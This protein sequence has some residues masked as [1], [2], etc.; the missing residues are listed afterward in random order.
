MPKRRRNTRGVLCSC[1]NF[2][3]EIWVKKILKKNESSDLKRNNTR[4]VRNRLLSVW[5][6]GPSWR[7]WR[8]WRYFPLVSFGF[9]WQR[10]SRTSVLC[11]AS[12]GLNLY[13]IPVKWNDADPSSVQTDDPDPGPNSALYSTCSLCSVC[14]DL[15]WQLLYIIRT[16]GSRVTELRGFSKNNT[17]SANCF[18][19]SFFSLFPA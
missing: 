6:S 1:L 12:P 14:S 11:S 9:L 18:C 7:R 19:F 16:R 5:H 2:I 8:W 3:S 17:E 10:L 15:L 13:L 4:L